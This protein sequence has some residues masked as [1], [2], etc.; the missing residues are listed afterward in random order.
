MEAVTSYMRESG[1]RVGDTLPGEAHF[2]EKLNVSRAVMREAYG[3]LAALRII[4]VGNGRKPRV[5]AIDG[6]V[7]AA[8][9]S[10]GIGT[11]QI[12]VPEVWEVRSTI[13]IRTARLAA[14]LR[15]EAEAYEILTIADAMVDTCDRIDAVV[16]ADIA[17]HQAIARASHNA[18]FIQIVRAFEPLMQIA[19]AVAWRTR[20][21]KAQRSA[22]AQN[23]LVIAQAIGKRD[24]NAAAKA[25]DLHF[26]A[27]VGDILERFRRVDLLSAA[28]MPIALHARPKAD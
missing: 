23:H 27:T 13:E 14:T 15:T 25:M 9:L 22:I 11:A 8:S 24:A 19:T 16:A 17:F 21:T 7:M 28:S 5:S 20:T 12:S 4:D 18:L 3:A 1:L 10:H 6:S 2:A 26:D